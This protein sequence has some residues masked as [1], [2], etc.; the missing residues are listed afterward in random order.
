M[1]HKPP[2]SPDMK[3]KL[4]LALRAGDLADYTEMA[5][6]VARLRSMAEQD[7]AA[8]GVDLNAY[9]NDLRACM[10]MPL[11]STVA[12]ILEMVEMMIAEAIEDHEE[13]FHHMSDV[14]PNLND[15][16]ET[17]VK[18][19]EANAR[20]V[21][22][23]DAN[24]RLENE[25]ASLSLRLKD[26]ESKIAEAEERA[27]K[28]E[29]EAVSL[30]DQIAKRDEQA[31]EE[32]V[33]SA[34][35]TYKDA[36]K[37]SDDDKAAMRITLKSDRALFDRLYPAVP[38]GQQHL[39]R[40]VASQRAGIA[41]QSHNG[42]VSMSDRRVTVDAV[43]REP[44]QPVLTPAEQVSLADRL[45]RERHMDAGDANMLAFRVARGTAANPF[46]S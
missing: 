36:K 31:I 12:E 46:S 7:G 1:M 29:A 39:L 9:C 13:E 27:T 28:A 24:K 21:A 10:G 42:S 25:H 40:H 34:F 19:G 22:L 32:R 26:A 5:S 37:L 14:A 8:D 45:V 2:M 6:M 38:P 4:R 44:G 15:S 16:T 43:G 20:L 3:A 23:T 35:D 18:L 11:G 33:A 17:A 30:R 41:P